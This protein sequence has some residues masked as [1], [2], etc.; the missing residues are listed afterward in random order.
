MAKI[1]YQKEY[2]DEILVYS[3]DKQSDRIISSTPGYQFEDG[4]CAIEMHFYDGLAIATD[5]SGIIMRYPTL[6]EIKQDD[7]RKEKITDYT[8]RDEITQFEV[9]LKYGRLDKYKLVTDYNLWIMQEGNEDKDIW[10]VNT[11]NGTFLF[12]VLEEDYIQIPAE[13]LEC[14][15]LDENITKEQIDDLRMRYG[16]LWT[17]HITDDITK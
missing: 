9:A 7:K 6:A 3:S 2:I 12:D 13:M 5:D 8:C 14:G 17:E 15:C 4:E 1:D 11:H 10:A 16:I